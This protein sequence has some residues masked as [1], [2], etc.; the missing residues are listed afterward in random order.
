M[1]FKSLMP[2]L[3]VKDVGKT[4]EFYKNILGFNVLGTVPEN[5]PFVFAIV[6]A[7]NVT[8]SFQ[9]EKSI[10]EEYAQLNKFASAGGGFTLY[11]NVTDVN[12][13]FEKVKEKATIAKEMH[14]TFYGSTDFSIE[15]CNGY[16]L[17]FSQAG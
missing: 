9:E 16:I 8:I 14:K 7:N 15:D 11:I 10:K 13:L 3:M 4:I 5:G 17:T 12:G 6:N 2:N 1:E